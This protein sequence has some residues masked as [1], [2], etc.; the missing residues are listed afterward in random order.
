ML[1]RSFPSRGRKT[2][3]MRTSG[4]SWA[5]HSLGSRSSRS[6]DERDE[7]SGSTWATYSL[8]LRSSRSGHAATARFET[9]LGSI[10]EP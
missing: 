2:N 4:S 9:I 6:G 7:N 1:F 5:T 8:G 3:V 10:S